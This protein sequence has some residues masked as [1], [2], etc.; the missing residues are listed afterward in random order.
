MRVAGNKKLTM[1]LARSLGTRTPRTFESAA[2]VREYPVVAKAVEGS[3]SVRYVNCS[4]ELS[5]VPAAGWLLQEYVPGEGYGFFALFNHGK[6]RAFFM[7]RRM[8]EYPI[9]G[10][11]SSAAESVYDDE[12]RAMGSRLLENLNWH[13]VAMVEF[14]KDARDGHYTLM[15]INPKFWGSLGL[16][17]ASGVDFP[18]L[19]AMM[20]VNGD[21]DP[22]T[23]YRVG[24]RFRWPLPDD[25]LHVLANPK[26]AREFVRD[27][28]DRSARTDL[29]L[30]DPRPN[31]FQ[32][33]LTARAI[34]SRV[35][36]GNLRYPHGVPEVAA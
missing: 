28:L 9:T 8:R 5:R 35:R 14:K 19:A 17:I 11:P 27:C 25:V 34:V 6:M 26:A 10:G 4:E 15:E 2:D 29:S 20:A 1:R 36:A 16:A 30:R 12:L 23:H 32:L 24:V 3:G 18:Y 31:L 22:L 13:G 7:H 21:V 33:A